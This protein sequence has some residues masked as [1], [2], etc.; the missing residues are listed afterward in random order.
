MMPNKEGKENAFGRPFDQ[1]CGIGEE[2]I[3]MCDLDVAGDEAL[4]LDVSSEDG[5]EIDDARYG[6][7]LARSR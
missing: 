7:H 1:H 5:S 3:A 4:G 2:E 6:D